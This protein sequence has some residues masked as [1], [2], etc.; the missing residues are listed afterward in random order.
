MVNQKIASD[1]RVTLYTTPT[2]VYCKIAKEFFRKHNISFRE[3]DVFADLDAREE[4]FSK[5]HQMGV[6]VIEI[7]DEIFV[8]FDRAI[9]ARALRI[10]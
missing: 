5:S 7:G 8:G 3:V 1:N 2:C 6:P 10:S 9:V 4:M